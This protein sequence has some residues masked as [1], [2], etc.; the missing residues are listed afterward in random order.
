M[1]IELGSPVSASLGR[2][3]VNI[4]SFCCCSHFVFNVR[5]EKLCTIIS[6]VLYE[7][8]LDLVVLLSYFTAKI[9]YEDPQASPTVRFDA[10]LCPPSSKN[11]VLA[12]EEGCPQ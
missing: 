8:L 5:F 3:R 12:V 11:S 9:W 6:W 1:R 10:E 7:V 2:I 4:G